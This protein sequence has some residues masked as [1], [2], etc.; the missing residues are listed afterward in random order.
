M[1]TKAAVGDCKKEPGVNNE[2][3]GAQM[4]GNLL[5]AESDTE[6][7]HAD[8]EV[9][10]TCPSNGHP[11][12]DRMPDDA[13]SHS[14]ALIHI[15]SN[16]SNSPP[17]SQQQVADE[18]G[19]DSDADQDEVDEDENERDESLDDRL[20]CKSLPSS[21][22]SMSLSQPPVQ[23]LNLTYTALT[24][25]SVKLK[26]NVQSATSEPHPVLLLLQEREKAAGN[27]VT[28]HYIAEMLISSSKSCP[29]DQPS[30]AVSQPTVT[31]RTVY[32][33]NANTC[34]VYLQ[35]AQQYSFRVRAV[36][37]S[38]RDQHLLV[39]NL[40]TITTPEQALNSKN[41]HR[42]KLQATA[43]NQQT[44]VNPEQQHSSIRSDKGNSN[45]PAATAVHDRVTES[46]DEL[47]EKDDQRRAFL[48][49]FLFTGFAVILSIII[50]HLLAG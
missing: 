17:I 20:M 31:A 24:A 1:K 15:T 5:N 18:I 16:A 44:A 45:H 4:N 41:K 47:Q 23:L 11:A 10:V 14:G 30:D 29:P 13:D 39:S 3:I 43:Q 35:C 7:I 36:V 46:E 34:R 49:L 27:G 22:K 50:H 12:G 37:K 19:G 2:T 48:I 42:A 33:G 28:H 26:W 25:T 38:L 32:Q 6:T 40:L 8:N 9:E 21:P